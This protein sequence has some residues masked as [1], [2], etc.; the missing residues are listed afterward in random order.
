M[1]PAASFGLIG[2][3][4]ECRPW[5]PRA[6][7]ERSPVDVGAL[8][9]TGGATIAELRGRLAAA[10]IAVSRSAL[11]RFL[12]AAG[13]TRKKRLSTPP[14]RTGRTSPPPGAPGACGSPS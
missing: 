11:G 4:S 8:N 14:S 10:G 1:L 13:L 6:A 3:G 9:S 7:V 2:A 5:G 12:I